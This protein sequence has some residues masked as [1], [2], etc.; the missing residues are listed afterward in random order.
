VSIDWEGRRGIYRVLHVAW[1]AISVRCSALSV[2][3]SNGRWSAMPARLVVG[4][5]F[6][7]VAAIDP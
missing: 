1:R 3:A 6:T 7:D 5:S 2:A 4:G